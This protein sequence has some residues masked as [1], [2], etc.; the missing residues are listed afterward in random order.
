MPLLVMLRTD[1]RTK[2][3]TSK[4]SAVA[5]VWSV[6][7]ERQKPMQEHSA[8]KHEKKIGQEQYETE[9]KQTLNIKPT[10]TYPARFG[11]LH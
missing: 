7:D 4:S 6:S 9:E 10:K 8:S 2:I 5:F 11:R 1:Q 3:L